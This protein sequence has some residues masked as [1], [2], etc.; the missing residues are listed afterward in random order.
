[1][2][3]VLVVTSDSTSIRFAAYDGTSPGELS[4]IGKG[5]V[6]LSGSDIEFFVKNA[7]SSH[8]EIIRSKPADG[9][10]DHDQAMAR[11]YRWVD[12]H[13]GFH[14]ARSDP[15]GGAGSRGSRSSRVQGGEAGLSRRRG[16]SRRCPR[17]V[18]RGV[19]SA[20]WLFRDDRCRAGWRLRSAGRGCSR[21]SFD[22]RGRCRNGV[23]QPVVQ[24]S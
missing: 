14:R 13:C 22:C 10:F 24:R 20:P 17:A 18:V 12:R 3:A 6:A 19:E 23:A 9:A 2:Q 16:R 15:S 7:T 11:M 4:L 5:H 1:M 21:A 8:P